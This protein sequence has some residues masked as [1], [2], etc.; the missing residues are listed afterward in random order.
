MW[1]FNRKAY[2]CIMHTHMQTNF[3]LMHPEE[4]VWPSGTSTTTHKAVFH[5]N[6]VDG[7]VQPQFSVG[8]AINQA[9]SIVTATGS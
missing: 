9:T 4:E 6:I 1:W 5:P 8:V 3:S 2:T 7:Y